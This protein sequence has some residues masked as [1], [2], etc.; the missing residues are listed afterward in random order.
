MNNSISV[1]LGS[2]F[3]APMGYP[4]GMDLNKK[5]LNFDYDLFAFSHEGELIPPSNGKKIDLGFK[6]PYDYI[7]E[8]CIELIKYFKIS[9]NYFDYEEFYDYLIYEVEKDKQAEELA[10]NYLI[11]TDFKQ[12]VF[13][14]SD[15]YS[16]VVL[17]FLKDKN[18]EQ[19]YKNRPYN[20]DMTLKGYT[21]FL[22]CLHNFGNNN[23]INIHTLNHDLFLE[24]LTSAGFFKGK[25]SDGFDELNSPHYGELNHENRTYNCRLE[26]YFGV[27]TGNYRLYKLHGSIDYG[28]YYTNKG[29]LLIPE[30]YVK[31]KYG[32][33]FNEILK[34]EKCLSG[35]SSYE[36]CWINY[37]ADFMT[38]TTSKIE[39]Y[40][41]P[42]LFKKLF[43]FFKNNLQK[44]DKLII[45]GYGAKDEEINKII[46][47][48][49]DFNNKSSFIID[50]FPSEKVHELQKSLNAKIIS[51]QL[52]QITMSDFD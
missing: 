4:T 23:I 33:G 19:W 27:Y 14:L 46:K 32:I 28:V 11:Y 40:K 8:Y 25:L 10:Q 29:G 15:V 45:V 26:T 12:L 37:H 38:G 13:G 16:Q 47:Q 2:G 22:K 30:N 36:S 24:S 31:T 17:Y 7:F 44:A 5:L 6:N 3:S 50:P 34:E 43:D 48:H 9:K 21:G 20:Y 51:K 52:E 18:N 42:L 1:L 39:R 35:N 41:E 49:F